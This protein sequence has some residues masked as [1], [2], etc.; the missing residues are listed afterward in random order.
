MGGINFA[1]NMI[2][3]LSFFLGSEAESVCLE[4]SRMIV[5]P[6]FRF[7]AKRNT[8]GGRG[9]SAF[10]KPR[11]QHVAPSDDFS[12]IRSVPANPTESDPV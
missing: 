1:E 10:A 12:I 4:W 2:H 3:S 11:C 9:W 6:I 7:A 5:F 8:V